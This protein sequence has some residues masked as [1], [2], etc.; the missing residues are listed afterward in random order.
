M[1]TMY[2]PLQSHPPHTGFA[3]FPII[4]SLISQLA[5]QDSHKTHTLP[6][7]SET[8]CVLHSHFTQPPCTDHIF[9]AGLHLAHLTLHPGR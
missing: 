1:A 8:A 9:A 5:V 3:C 7:L 6:V 2:R 4:I